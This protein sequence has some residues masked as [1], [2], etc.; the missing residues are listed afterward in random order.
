MWELPLVLVA[1]LLGSAHCIGMCGPFALAMG[2]TTSG[3][4]GN[5]RRHGIYTL[6][7]V[8]TYFFIG[9]VAGF[10]GWKFARSSPSWMNVPAA[11]AVLAGL[12]LVYQGL[13]AAGLGR[14]SVGSAKGPCLTGTFLAS[15]LT[16][17]RLRETFLAG[18]FTGLLPCGLVYAFAAKAAATGDVLLGGATMA[19]F[20]LGTAPVMILTGLGGSLMSWTMRKRV[21]AVAA[22]CIVLT[23]VISIARGVGAVEIPGWFES[24][25]CPFCEPG[26]PAG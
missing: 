5:L 7:R 12:L 11:L 25:G 20:G 10:G 18:L 3:L 8:F 14:P 26:Q 9:A 6:G 24:A 1:G 21:F 19:V 13:K 23:G 15:F 4:A 17:G 2:S 22:W 16:S